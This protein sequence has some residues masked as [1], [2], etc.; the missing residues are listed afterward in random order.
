MMNVIFVICC[1]FIIIFFMVVG[2]LVIG[3]L[4]VSVV[5]SNCE[6]WVGLSEFNE[7]LFW[8]VILFS[9]EIVVWVIFFDIGNGVMIQIFMNINEE[10]CVDWFKI[11]VEYVDINC[12]FWE[13]NVYVKVGGWIVYF[14]GWFI[15]EECMEIV[16]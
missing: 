14:S 7:F 1:E 16:F 6:F 8:F 2:G 9:G 15:G 3:V 4:F 10:L 12:N 11:C 13:D 5:F